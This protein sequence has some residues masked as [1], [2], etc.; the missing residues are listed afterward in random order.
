M[1]QWAINLILFL[2]SIIAIGIA[3][4]KVTPFEVTEDTYIGVTVT[5]LALATSFVIGY[6]I[7]NAIELK[8]EIS[9][10]RKQYS[11]IVQESLKMDKRYKEQNY[12]MQEGFDILSSLIYYNS[13]QSSIVCNQAFSAL[14][15]ALVSSVKTNRT[16]YEWIFSYL[17]LY[18]YQFNRQT[19]GFGLSLHID[20]NHT[21]YSDGTN[22]IRFLKLKDVVEEY[23]TPIKEDEKQLRADKNFCKIQCEYNRVM[24]IFYDRINSILKDPQKELS[25]E[26]RDEIIN[27]KY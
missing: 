9:K 11:K 20:G 17:R 2:L 21:V 24:K 14:H 10:Q 6:Q 16:D 7:Y 25:P 23:L 27:P 5:L 8:K 22:N 18:I 3:L 13:G 15:H 26:E 12:R 1:K 4:F 19:F